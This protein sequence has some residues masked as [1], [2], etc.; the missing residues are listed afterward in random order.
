MNPLPTISKPVVF[1]DSSVWFSAYGFGWGYC[2]FSIPVE[3]VCE[4]LG[5]ANATHNQLTLAFELGKKRVSQAVEKN[6][7]QDTGGR[8][9]LRSLDG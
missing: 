8:V 3:I 5:A 9:A 1:S 4:Q 7:V 2:A 6:Y